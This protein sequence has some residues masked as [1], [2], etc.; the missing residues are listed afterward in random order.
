MKYGKIGE[1]MQERFLVLM[2]LPKRWYVYTGIEIIGF[3]LFGLNVYRTDDWTGDKPFSEYTSRDWML[4]KIFLAEELI[5]LVVIIVF[6]VLAYRVAR[7]RQKER[8]E[9]FYEHS[10]MAGIKP[11]DYDDVWVNF[12]D[13]A[14][15]MISKHG[16]SFR[17]YVDGY[18]ERAGNWT[19]IVGPSFY[20]SIDEIKKTLF[21]EYDFYCVANAVLD[22]QGNVKFYD[23]ESKDSVGENGQ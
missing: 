3:L 14:R 22:E 8:Q 4:L 5:I 7:K 13:S 10:L 18:D 12:S 15:A 1:K 16:N 2:R 20:E 23:G 17:L 11:G 19:S 9:Y 6:M 21:Y